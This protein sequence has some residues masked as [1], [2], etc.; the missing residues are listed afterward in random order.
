MAL[1]KKF[2]SE[3]KILSTH[4]HRSK[5]QFCKWHFDL[6]WKYVLEHWNKDKKIHNFLNTN[7][8]LTMKT[9]IPEFES[10]KYLFWNLTYMKRYNSIKL[11][12]TLYNIDPFTQWTLSWGL[13]VKAKAVGCVA[14]GSCLHDTTW[15][16]PL[17]IRIWIST[18]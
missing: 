1:V 2:L 9:Q 18:P 16:I 11:V 5:I 13:V 6:S 14:Q 4:V 17:L 10:F 15:T 12:L 3:W 8:F 7:F